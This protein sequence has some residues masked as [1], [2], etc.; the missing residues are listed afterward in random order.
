[1]T[2]RIKHKKI[3][4]GAGAVL[5]DSF[6]ENNEQNVET[7]EKIKTLGGEVARAVV[8]IYDVYHIYV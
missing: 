3:V 2:Q 4:E 8:I 1:M 7:I 6:Y 5:I